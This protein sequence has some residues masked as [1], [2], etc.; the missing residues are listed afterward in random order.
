MA[1]GVEGSGTTAMTRQFVSSKLVTNSKTRI[2][3]LRE[4]VALDGDPG[5]QASL[6]KLLIEEED[7]LA[8]NR[9]RLEGS[10][11]VVA[12]GK[13]R[14]ERLKG[15]KSSNTNLNDH[16]LQQ[17]MELTQRLFE[18]FHRRLL[19]EYPYQINIQDRT[20]GVCATLDE[21]RRRAEQFADANPGAIVT[22][23]DAWRPAKRGVNSEC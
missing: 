16:G 15:I 6:R 9:E 19:T 17:V 20:V 12:D 22:I 23:V 1:G 3:D 8:I 7:K 5:R 21:A 11:R 14:I 13:A 10:A 2:I 4:L 18:N